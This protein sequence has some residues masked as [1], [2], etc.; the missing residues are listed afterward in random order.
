MLDLTLVRQFLQPL[1]FARH[2]RVDC[3]LEWQAL[4]YV[5]DSDDLWDDFREEWICSLLT[6]I[7]RVNQV[8]L[9]LISRYQGYVSL[10]LK[11]FSHIE[12]N[13]LLSLEDTVLD[14]IICFS[15]FF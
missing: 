1:L 15:Q 12:S 10:T 2:P 3:G 13:R 7:Y 14:T 5:I 9:G 8:S 6:V 11:H 4:V